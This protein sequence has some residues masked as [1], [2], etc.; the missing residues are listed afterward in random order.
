MLTTGWYAGDDD[1]GL[2]AKVLVE[3]TRR[4]QPVTLQSR[5][6]FMF[7]QRFSYLENG[8]C[9]LIFSHVHDRSLPLL[10]RHGAVVTQVSPPDS[11]S[12]ASPDMRGVA[13]VAARGIEGDPAR[14][15]QSVEPGRLAPFL[16]FEDQGSSVELELPGATLRSAWLVGDA[17]SDY[18]VESSVDRADWHPLGQF[19][20]SGDLLRAPG[21]PDT[22]Y[23]WVRLRRPRG[24]TGRLSALNFEFGA[25]RFV[26]L[27]SSGT[28]GGERIV[29]GVGSAVRGRSRR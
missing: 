14:L 16:R 25:W 4:K 9:E 10:S 26:L 19:S 11:E 15:I 12:R 27:D 22:A 6:R 20:S 24:F 21:T 5:H 1:W 7:G 2:L 28:P 17:P 18:V 23:A 13:V 3:L 8:Q 29:D